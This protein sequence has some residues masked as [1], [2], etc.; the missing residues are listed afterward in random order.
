[1][2]FPTVL[3]GGVAMPE[4]V[5]KHRHEQDEHIDDESK[6]NVSPSIRQA[7]QQ[8][9]GPENGKE[10]MELHGHHLPL[11]V[12]RAHLPRPLLGERVVGHAGRVVSRTS[13]VHDEGRVVG[14][15]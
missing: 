10:E 5:D 2:A 12:N 14:R 8:A 7:R 13:A 11:E 6:A 3:N 15:G 1:M 4:L 9:Q